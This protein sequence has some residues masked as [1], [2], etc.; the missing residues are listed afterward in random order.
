MYVMIQGGGDGVY[1][2]SGS[3][4][5]A[6]M[7]CEHERQ[8]LMEKGFKPE[9]FFHQYSDFVSTGEVID[10]IDHN[11]KKHSKKDAII[12]FVFSLVTLQLSFLCI[13]PLFCFFI[14]IL[15]VIFLAEAT[16]KRKNYLSENKRVEFALTKASRICSIIGLILTIVLSVLGFIIFYLI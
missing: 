9:A 2:N 8:E 11:K 12:S 16:I 10:R 15:N 3:C 6:A 5:A 14:L 13:I 7:Y 1:A 4:V